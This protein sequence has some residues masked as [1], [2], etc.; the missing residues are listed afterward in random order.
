[1]ISRSLLYGT[2]IDSTCLRAGFIVRVEIYVFI[3]SEGATKWI[4]TAPAMMY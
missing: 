3:R 2:T 1:M 4:C